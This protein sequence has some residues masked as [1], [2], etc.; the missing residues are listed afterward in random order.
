MSASRGVL[1]LGAMVVALAVAGCPRGGGNADTNEGATIASNVAGGGQEANRQAPAR[2]VPP[3]VVAAPPAMSAAS[4]FAVGA[5]S[6]PANIGTNVDP[7]SYYGVSQQYVDILRMGGSWTTT[8]SDPDYPGGT[9]LQSIGAVDDHGWP[10][11]DASIMVV[12][13]VASNGSD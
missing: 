11:R 12:C 5:A 9:S 6:A 1:V 8:S 10:M 13:C 3:P 4:T 7:I 2:D